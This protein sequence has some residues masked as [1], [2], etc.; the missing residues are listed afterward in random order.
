MTGSRTK[1]NGSKNT[2]PRPSPIY[3]N[4]IRLMRPKVSFD[5]QTLNGTDIITPI[6]ATANL[7]AQFFKV[8]CSNV[9]S[10]ASV[11]SAITAFYSEYRFTSVKLHWMPSVAPGVAAAGGR[12]Y[13]TSFT[14][15][16]Q[17]TIIDASSTATQVN[18]SKTTRDM[19][20]WNAW[21]RFTYNMPIFYRRK[22]FD[23]NTNITSDIN[24]YDRS[25]QS[26]ILVGSDTIG[27]TDTLGQF[28]IEFSIEL[29]GLNVVGS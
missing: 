27:A 29:R 4:R 1:R 15:P 17:M 28:R 21:E 2:K 16:E 6:T 20:S 7:A 18:L 9:G 10:V 25:V 5:G 12:L 3:Q 26:Y 24:Q 11:L 23:V 13:L 22:W 14:N 8:D 19:K